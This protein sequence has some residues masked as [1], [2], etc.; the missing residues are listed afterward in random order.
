MPESKSAKIVS[1]SALPECGRFGVKA[2]NL[3]RVAR[4]KLPVPPG[5]G[6]AVDAY[7]E[8]M[9]QSGAWELAEQLVGQRPQLA[10]KEKR[11]RLE[12][13]R[14]RLL[15]AI[16]PIAFR[17]EFEP[18]FKS[19]DANRLAV[20]S[21]G[22]AEDLSG[23]SFAGLYDTILFKGDMWACLEAVKKCWAS[24]WSDRAFEYREKNRI[25]H[26]NARMAVI[27][28]KMVLAESS[29]VC[30]TADPITGDAT[31]L[32]IESS[33]GLGEAIVAGKVTPDRFVLARHGLR[34]LERNINRKEIQVVFSSEWGVREWPIDEA[35]REQPSVDESIVRQVARMALRIE[36]SFGKPQDIEWAKSDSELVILQARPITTLSRERQWAERQ[37]WTN[38]NV[39]EALPDVA[40][41]MA[42]SL[43]DL[44]FQ[45]IVGWL[46]EFVGVS[47]SEYPA[48]DWK[49]GRPYVNLNTLM[50]VIRSIP[51]I[52][53]MR[54][55]ELFGGL[56]DE[57]APKPDDVPEIKVNRLKVL[58]RL[59]GLAIW[60][61]TSQPGPGRKAISR[62]REI[63][64]RLQRLDY[65]KWPE[66][67]LPEQ[68]THG[69]GQLLS[70]AS[71]L[72]GAMTGMMYYAALFDLCRKWFKDPESTVASHLLTSLGDIESAQS[73]LDLWRLA[74]MAGAR[75]E[76]KGLI[77]SGEKWETLRPKLAP[78]ELGDEFLRRWDELMFRH[79][80]HCRGEIDVAVPRW[81]ERPDFV[82]DT[83]RSFLRAG[84]TIN[85]VEEFLH[86]V[87]EREQFTEECRR[88]LNPLKRPLF[89]FLLRR[90][91]SGACVREN[92]RNDSNRRAAIARTVLLVLGNR[93][94]QRDI[95]EQADDIFYLFLHELEPV[96]LK[97]QTFDVRNT[98][99]DRKAEFERYRQITPP[100]VITGRFDLA[101]FVPEPVNDAVETLS[102][103]AV[104]PGVAT[105]PARV[106]ARA[107]TEEQVLPGEILVAPFTDPG[108]TPYFLPAAGIVVDIGGLL[109][110]GSIVARE[111]GKPA[112]VNVGP[113]TRI[114]KTGQMIQVDGNT[115]RVHILDRKS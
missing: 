50:G 114:I 39:A 38:I 95:L 85:P 87:Q 58:L 7:V 25:D 84:D 22:T 3:A 104:S 32:V 60:F 46:L 74:D 52:G 11:R 59:P 54:L 67:Q 66:E 83:V 57:L 71:D 97:S 77:L 1:L 69:L 75:E 62:L 27:V 103:L 30:F 13:I 79:G 93:L 5:F 81:R 113:A 94:V 48:M 115:G 33:F 12:A 73:G 61:L 76:L 56:K 80:H 31:R 8:Q 91:Q 106:I 99:A 72:G 19:L 63:T 78:V 43:L 108:W 34:L 105:G 41:P 21:S 65:E 51:L 37:V 86:R 15:T 2:V 14:Q 47:A 89:D 109:S 49:A 16:L 107:S 101:R 88:R 36:Q 20:R 70:T 110:H 40:V 10:P 26:L 111:Y 45:G 9:Q 96:R 24:L 29:G 98:I 102:G 42:A 55:S 44:F 64:D 17:Q 18:Q 90:A 23:H 68:V 53:R 6:I 4:L 100:S 82:L 28:Q 92:L 35:K 112:V